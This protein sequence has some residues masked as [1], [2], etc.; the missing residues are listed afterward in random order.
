M[1]VHLQAVSRIAAVARQLF[2]RGE[3]YRVFHGSTNCT[4]PRPSVQSNKI[5]ISQLCNVLEIDTNSRKVLVEPNVPMDKLVAATLKHG[6]IPP[7]V[8]EF[9]GIT[10]EGGFASTGGESSSFKYGFFDRTVSSVEMVLADGQVVTASKER[11]A[12]LFYGV[13]GA[14]GTLGLVTMVEIDLIEA[15]KFVKTTYHSRPTVKQTVEV[16][17]KESSNQSNDYVDGIMFSKDHGAAITG[18]MTDET[19]IRAQTFSHATDP[20]FYLHVQDIT[21]LIPSKITEFIPLAEYLFRYD[22]GGFWV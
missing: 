7:V 1:E 20:W 19:P 6:L 21:R 10:V 9:P 3:P 22:R 13:P 18:E 2:N 11:N 8:M 14:L 15:K 4:R 16:V 17:Q 12:D 5:D